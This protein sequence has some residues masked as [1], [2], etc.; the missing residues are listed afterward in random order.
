MFNKQTKIESNIII[1]RRAELK[2]DV[3]EEVDEIEDDMPEFPVK[4][5]D[6]YKSIYD[7]DIDSIQFAKG[8]IRKSGKGDGVK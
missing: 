3:I 2:L 1:K 7:I 4:T 5:R 8:K 6:L